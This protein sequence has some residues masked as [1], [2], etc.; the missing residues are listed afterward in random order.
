MV[1]GAQKLSGKAHHSSKLESIGRI[2]RPEYA[3][4]GCSK[5]DYLII[6]VQ[7]VGILVSPQHNNNN[8]FVTEKEKR[9][10]TSF[11]AN[12]TLNYVIQLMNLVIIISVPDPRRHTTQIYRIR[13]G[14]ILLRTSMSADI[15][16]DTFCECVSSTRG[17][18]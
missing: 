17:T 1:F 5:H 7:I 4:A 9:T 11:S 2:A 12:K 15:N 3:T 16:E 10:P 6:K 18:L 14:Y 13:L 8:Y